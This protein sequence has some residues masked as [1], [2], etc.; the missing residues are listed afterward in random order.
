MVYSG[1]DNIEGV[2]FTGRTRT[3]NFCIYAR[4][5]I[6]I[7]CADRKSSPLCILY[8]ENIDISGGAVLKIKYKFISVQ[9]I[10]HFIKN[11]VSRPVK[12]DR[13]SC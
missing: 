9:R 11:V 4:R 7:F 1:T 10:I 8:D 6:S 12:S 5:E 2:S 13:F 3:M